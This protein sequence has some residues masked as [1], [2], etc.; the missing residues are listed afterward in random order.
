MA[1]LDG[2]EGRTA[3]AAIR[4]GILGSKGISV[5]GIG[6]HV[7]DCDVATAL[8]C[9]AADAALEC[10]GHRKYRAICWGRVVPG[11]AEG[12][13]SAKDS[14][15]VVGNDTILLA[16]GLCLIDQLVE[17][18]NISGGRTRCKIKKQLISAI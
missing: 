16:V 11:E 10:G 17:V 14:R 6:Q 15:R 3:A 5:L 7:V 4:N 13:V 1:C 8:N 9:G 12:S 2:T 18:N